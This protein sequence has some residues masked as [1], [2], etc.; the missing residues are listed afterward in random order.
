MNKIKNIY[1]NLF[2]KHGDSP[3]SVKARDKKQQYNRFKN[4]IRCCEISKNDTILDLGC[5][6]GEFYEFVK[7]FKISKYCGIDFLDE[8]IIAGRKKYKN[9]KKVKF[10]K[11]DFEKKLLPKNYDWVFLSG[12]FND[13][14]KNSKQI[15][16]KTLKKMYGAC[17]KGIVFNSLSKHVDYEDSKLFYSSPEDVLKFSAKNLSK[18]YVLRSDYQLKK[19]TIP[20]EYSMCIKKKI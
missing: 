20:F 17:K 19:D 15:M 4:L 10:K 1:R 5:G 11:L 14:K 6:S 3:I 12:S 16:Y 9:T 7:K 18:F 13:K 8:F 2:K